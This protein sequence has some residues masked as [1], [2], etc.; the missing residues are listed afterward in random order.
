MPNKAH[1]LLVTSGLF[2]MTAALLVTIDFAFLKVV[3][4]PMYK[5]LI[6]RIQGTAMDFKKGYAAYVYALMLALL[7]YF[8]V[9]KNAPFYEAFLLGFAVYGIYAFTNQSIFSLWDVKVALT[10]HAWGGALFT[11]VTLIVRLLQKLAA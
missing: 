8:I 3:L 6:G 1:D 7:Y 2:L 4:K 10:D 11:L 9:H 5:E